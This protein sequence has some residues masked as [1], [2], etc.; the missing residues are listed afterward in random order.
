MKVLIAG[1]RAARQ[2]HGARGG[3]AGHDVVGYGRAEMDVA[4]AER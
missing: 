1:A 4:D 2:G 3:N